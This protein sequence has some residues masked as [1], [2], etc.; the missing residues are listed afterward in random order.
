MGIQ[1]LVEKIM[2]LQFPCKEGSLICLHQGFRL[3]C[4][5]ST[6][7]ENGVV[8]QEGTK[9]AIGQKQRQSPDATF[10]PVRIERSEQEVE[11]RWSSESNLT[12]SNGMERKYFKVPEG[13]SVSDVPDITC[14]LN[15]KVICGKELQGAKDI[16]PQIAN[17]DP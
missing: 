4:E 11:R 16:E 5:E 2:G 17:I 13:G 10:S 9:R 7:R 12:I 15:H 8:S 1:I 14:K 6:L 3:S